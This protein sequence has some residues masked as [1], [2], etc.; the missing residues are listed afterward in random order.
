M[1]NVVRSY[2]ARSMR[3]ALLAKEYVPASS[4]LCQL[5]PVVRC[6]SCFRFYSYM[7]MLC[8][9]KALAVLRAWPC[10]TGTPYKGI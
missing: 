6:C 1:G 9:Y 7:V 2:A 8:N 4:T 3:H 10:Q 5:A